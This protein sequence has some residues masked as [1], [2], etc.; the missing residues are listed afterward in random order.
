[1]DITYLKQEEHAWSA[2]L[3]PLNAPYLQFRLAKSNTFC[4]M[5]S[6]YLVP[7]IVKLARQ[8]V[9]ACNVRMDIIYQH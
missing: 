6:V 3:E 9:R 5:V 2:P 8:S 1:M 7:K 4:Q